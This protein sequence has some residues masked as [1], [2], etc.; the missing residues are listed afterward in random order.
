MTFIGIPLKLEYVHTFKRFNFFI[1]TGLSADLML[2]NQLK[3]E[4]DYY[5]EPAAIEKFERGERLIPW[6]QISIAQD[7]HRIVLTG[8]IDFG[9]EIPLSN[10]INVRIAA[11]GTYGL[12]SVFKS[13]IIEH[14]WSF[15]GKVGLRFEL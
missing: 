14:L 1:N 6:H 4:I 2:R 9:L 5:W 11:N 12:T 7:A 13:P 15:G 3:A 10:R 8:L